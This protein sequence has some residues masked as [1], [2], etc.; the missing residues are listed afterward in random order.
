MRTAY[1]S[2][3]VLGLVLAAVAPAWGQ[4]APA[5]L[6]FSPVAPC[7]IVDTRLAGGTIAGNTQRSFVVSGVTDFEAQGGTVGGCAIPEGAAAVVVNFVAVNPAGPGDLRAWASGGPTPNASVLNYAPVPGLNI[8]NGVIVPLCAPGPCAFDLTVQADVSATDLVADVLGY[9]QGANL[10]E[11][12]RRVT[13]ACASGEAIRVVNGDGTVLCEPTRPDQVD[14]SF[15]VFVVCAA[16]TRFAV[17]SSNGTFSRGSAG[18]TASRL[19]VGT[20]VVSFDINVT[21]CSWQVTVGQ[22]GSVGTT[23]GV[24]NVAGRSG[25]AFGLFITTHDILP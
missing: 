17:V 18:T 21:T 10:G 13:G 11:L 2:M 12:Q 5:D 22:T 4:T 6:V 20:Y 23:T 24:G 19:T 7:R 1:Q 3:L 16:T 8:A 15:H 9:Y 14:R 25:N